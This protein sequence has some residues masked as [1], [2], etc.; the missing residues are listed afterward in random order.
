MNAIVLCGG[1]GSRLDGEREKP[2]RRVGGV[3]MVERVREGLRA[4]DSV[5][6]VSAAVS[7]NAP[8]TDEWARSAEGVDVIETPGEGYVADLGVALDAVGTPAVTVAADL[9]LL[10]GEHVDRAVAASRQTDTA[11]DGTASMRVLTPARLKRR[12]GVSAD[13]SADDGWLP[14]GLNVVGDGDRSVERRSWDARL[15]V[16]VNYERDLAA[17]EALLEGGDR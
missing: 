9:P 6:T 15:A 10:A 2:L 3:P 13:E 1:H 4:A 7:P 14:T 11:G 12:L 5:E 8:A 16:N 17:A